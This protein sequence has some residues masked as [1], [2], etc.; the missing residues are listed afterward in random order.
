MN[1]G[2][3][4]IGIVLNNN[5]VPWQFSVVRKIEHTSA[6]PGIANKNRIQKLV[7][8]IT[9]FLSGKNQS[10]QWAVSTF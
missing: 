4:M 7:P 2:F 9:V 1:K 10:V 8:M 3:R 5:A 6:K